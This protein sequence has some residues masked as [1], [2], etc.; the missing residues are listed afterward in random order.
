VRIRN[1]IQILKIPPDFKFISPQEGVADK[2]YYW[3]ERFKFVHMHTRLIPARPG[4]RRGIPVL[5][6]LCST[7]LANRRNWPILPYC[8]RR[9]ANIGHI[10]QHCCLFGVFG[11]FVK[12]VIIAPI[13]GPRRLASPIADLVAVTRQRLTT[14][15]I[16]T[17]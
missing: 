8:L 13:R 11:V 3:S 6:V 9:L 17:I 1:S 12:L 2:P 14:S 4:G 7:E 15:M 5:Y 10:D 16:Y